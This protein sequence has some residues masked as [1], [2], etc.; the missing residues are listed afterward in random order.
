MNKRSD[1]L[2]SHMFSPPAPKSAEAKMASI[3]QT[4]RVNPT[5]RRRERARV[6]ENLN[7]EKIQITKFLIQK[8]FNNEKHDISKNTLTANH[9]QKR[10]F[11]KVEKSSKLERLENIGM[12]NPTAREDR[13]KV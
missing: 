11:S 5:S 3:R 7:P 12:Q 1:M 8:T 10:G 9:M 2:N 6:I 13:R 4:H